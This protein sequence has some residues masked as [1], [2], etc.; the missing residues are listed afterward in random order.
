MSHVHMSLDNSSRRIGRLILFSL[1]A[2]FLSA[3]EY[4]E[5]FKSMAK[6]R[7]IEF[8]EIRKF[9]PIQPPLALRPS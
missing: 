4:L 3:G 5:I 8:L 1:Y 9:P 2:F 7:K 6:V